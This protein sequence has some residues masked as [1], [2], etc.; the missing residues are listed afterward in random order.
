MKNENNNNLIKQSI[1]FTQVPNDLLYDSDISFKAK[2]IWAYMHAK[3]EG[4]N[5]SA[6]RI[7]EET[8][9]DRKAILSGLK[10][11]S[12]NGYITAKKLSSGRVEYT[13]HWEVAKDKPA[14][15]EPKAKTTTSN[16]RPMRKDYDSDED[17]EKAIYKW[18]TLGYNKSGKL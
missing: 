10:E 13:L 16:M 15:S 5:F 8:K 3:P 18:G 11:L 17:Y 9:E 7:A 12:E 1:P 2:G 6:D 4:W 14:D